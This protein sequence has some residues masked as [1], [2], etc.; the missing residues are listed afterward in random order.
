MINRT[1]VAILACAALPAPYSGS[2]NCVIA[3]AL[4]VLA[5]L[6]NGR[7]GRLQSS[8][9]VL[10]LALAVLCIASALWSPVPA[11]TV[12][13]ATAIL[14]LT[15]A[16]WIIASRMSLTDLL[17]GCGVAFRLL[18][19]TSLLLVIV[20]PD[21]GLVSDAYEQGAVKGLF[22][23]RN[24]LSFVSV[25]AAITFFVS[26]KARSRKALVYL[27]LLV[28]VYCLYAAKSSSA[29]VVIGVVVLLWLGMGLARKFNG[30]TRMLVSLF[31]ASSAA[32]GVILALTAL[33]ELF[34]GLGRD[35]TLTGRT[36]IWEAVT[37]E[38][39]HQPLLGG[40][41]MGVWHRGLAISYR[42][43]SVT[44]F[45]VYHAHNGYLDML[46]QLG[47]LGLALLSGILLFCCMWGARLAI[48]SNSPITMW[49]IS[50]AV[51]LGIANITESEFT[52]FGGLLILLLAYFYSRGRQERK[53]GTRLT[54]NAKWV[55]ERRQLH[56]VMLPRT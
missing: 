22:V 17:L 27:D 37:A 25:A 42:I 23:H 8:N 13:G 10:P 28:A 5:V 36:I 38:V 20:R 21:I 34:G 6:L 16:A 26:R 54:G 31:I 56:R 19:V 46:L 51:A 43:W 40:G 7:T 48:R 39:Q 35:T 33:P 41:W 30:A 52:T 49:P 3:A 45:E 15:L 9:I 24:I 11:V 2:E 18:L 14:L 47:V 44:G 50:S 55:S 53:P 4:L 1:A 12:R 29:V 32:G